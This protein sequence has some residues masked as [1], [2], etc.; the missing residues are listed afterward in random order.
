MKKSLL[1]AVFAIAAFPVMA[2]QSPDKAAGTQAQQGVETPEEF[3]KQLA[4][5]QE[6]M[7]KMQKQMDQIR[8]TQDPQERQKL[9]EEH[10]T[11]MQS[12]MGMMQGM[13][14]P[15]MMRG[16]GMSGGSGMMEPGM[17]WGRMGDYYNQLTP[18]QLK[19]R[20]YM[21]DQRMQTHQMMMNQ[22]MQHQY[23][24]RQSQ[25]PAKQK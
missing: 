21:M 2:Q 14:G 5:M 24:S 4:Q 9:L 12:S 6:N 3:D 11:T 13:G 25:E 1:A 19:Q 8:Q 20:Q 10:W 16:R 18:E 23:W 15:G 17:G 22:M 7:E